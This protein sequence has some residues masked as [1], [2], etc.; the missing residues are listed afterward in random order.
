MTTN[1][2]AGYLLEGSKLQHVVVAEKALG[3]PIPKGVEVH[4]VNGNRKDNS[5]ANLVLCPDRAYHVL[6][7]MRQKALEACGDA[8]KRRCTYCKQWDD[9]NSMTIRKSKLQG[10]EYRHKACHTA[11]E[12]KRT[13]RIS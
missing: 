12:A 9:V 2:S 3:K 5:G 7:H 11:Y 10:D 8:S 13:G 1:H 6:L 4:H